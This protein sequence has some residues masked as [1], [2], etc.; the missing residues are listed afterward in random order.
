M[1]LIVKDEWIRIP[2]PFGKLHLPASTSY[3]SV[4]GLLDSLLSLVL[5]CRYEGELGFFDN[6]I[7]PL[8]KKLKECGVFGVSSA[9]YL[10]YAQAN[11]E[12]WKKKGQ[13]VLAGYREKH[14][15]VATTTT[16]ATTT[17]TSSTSSS[18]SS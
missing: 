7:I 18:P 6:Y 10:T 3:C 14:C 16:T 8:A 2:V 15:G 13:S 5:H 12:E 9:E 1:K 4:Y 11:R 17:A